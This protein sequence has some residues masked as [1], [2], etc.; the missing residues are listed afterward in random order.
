MHFGIGIFLYVILW[1]GLIAAAVVAI[2]I[3]F[4][5]QAKRLKKMEELL[6]EI[7]DLNK[8]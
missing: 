8:K 4:V 3:Y 2:V 1:Y 5:R 6:T 7:R